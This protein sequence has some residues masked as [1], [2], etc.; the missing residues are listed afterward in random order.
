MTGGVDCTVRVWDTRT[1]LLL[2]HAVLDGHKSPV[3]HIAMNAED[4][5][6]ISLSQDKVG[7]ETQIR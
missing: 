5:V 1:T 4:H 6:I 7:R 2:S 3:G